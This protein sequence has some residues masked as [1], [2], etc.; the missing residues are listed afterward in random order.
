M[1]KDKTN[2]SGFSP[3]A[4]TASTDATVAEAKQKQLNANKRNRRSTILANLNNSSS[5]GKTLLGS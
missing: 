3:V 2:S 5:G 1:K 4:A